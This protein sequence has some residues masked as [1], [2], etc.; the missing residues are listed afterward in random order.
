MH[1]SGGEVRGHSLYGWR[2]DTH[3]P[4][5]AS[6][7]QSTAD[8]SNAFDVEFS[9][10][11]REGGGAPGSSDEGLSPP[12]EVVVELD[13]S[14]E[15]SE[16]VEE[17]KSVEVEE[18][19]VE[20]EDEVVGSSDAAALLGGDGLPR[21]ERLGV[22]GGEFVRGRVDGACSDFE[23]GRV[24]GADREGDGNV[25][26]GT[27][28]R[29]GDGIGLRTGSVVGGRGK[30]AGSSAV[31]W[32]TPGR[33]ESGNAYSS[34]AR[35][36]AMVATTKHRERLGRGR[37]EAASAAARALTGSVSNIVLG[38]SRPSEAGCVT[39]YEIQCRRVIIS[40]FAARICVRGAAITFHRSRR[41][42]RGT[43][44]LFKRKKTPQR[45]SPA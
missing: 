16:E 2:V 17:D 8:C 22:A 24:A 1:F 20:D 15:L 33:E 28:A 40:A 36:R 35:G 10:A 25:I 34:S 37:W 42:T 21:G 11:P 44:R 9:R 3:F 12:S 31:N 4:L 13:S 41:E 27:F 5:P 43:I 19:E 7:Q 6:A 14:L 18:S 29:A 26:G 23:G 39:A 45:A 38:G 30:A 32:T